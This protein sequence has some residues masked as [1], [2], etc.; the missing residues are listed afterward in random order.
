MPLTRHPLGLLHLLRV[1]PT[2]PTVLVMLRLLLLCRMLCLLRRMHCLLRRP[3]LQLGRALRLVCP[4]RLP[5]R[6]APSWLGAWLQQWMLTRL[7][8]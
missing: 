8:G 6:G 4:V 2:T 1:V 7:G 5:R 3:A